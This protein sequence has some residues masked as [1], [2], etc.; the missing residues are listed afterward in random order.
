MIERRSEVA[1]ALLSARARE[2][3]MS[4]VD[5]Q[6]AVQLA[7]VRV[8]GPLAGLQRLGDRGVVLL[9]QHLEQTGVERFLD[10]VVIEHELAPG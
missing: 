6:R 5:G 8:R 2:E 10:L 4:Q 7:R 1:Q 3:V 9:A